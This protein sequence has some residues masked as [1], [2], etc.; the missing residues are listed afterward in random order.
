MPR[1][2]PLANGRMLVNF[3]AN[4][5]LR[6]IYWPHIG[7][8][9]HTL[10]HVNHSGVWVDG[11][12]SWF[13]SDGWQRDLRYE[14]DTLT[15]TVTLIHAGLQLRI[16]C[17]DAVDFYR[18]ILIRRMRVTNQAD[19]PREV[20]LFFHHDWHIWE[21]EGANTVYYRPD[22]QVIIAYKDTCYLL[23]DGVVGDDL[24]GAPQQQRQGD[25]GVHHWAT[26]QKEFEGKQ[27]TW[28][29]AEDGVLGGNP[30]AQGSVDSCVG[31]HLGELAPNQTRT[32]YHWLVAGETY[33]AVHAQ[34]TAVRARGPEAFIVR[35]HNYWHLWV[36]TKPLGACEL[37]DELVDLYKRSL[38]I[39]RSQTD[40]SGAIIAAT[41]ADVYTFSAD[42]YAYMWPRDGAL[43]SIA[44]SHA[45]YGDITE[46]FFRFCAKAITDDGYLLHK[47]TPAGALGSS[48]H[49]WMNDK[50]Q[51]VHPIQEDET[52]LVVY[53]LW[54]HYLLFREVEFIR[55]LYRH[56][57]KA[58]ADFMMSFR[59]PHTGLPAPSWDLWEERHGI[60]TFT[61]ASV[62]G[63][64][65]AAANFAGQFGE[66][67]H[68]ARYQQAA[69]EIKTAA[70][71]Y[72]WHD[73]EQRFLRMINVGDDGSITPDMTVDSSVA[74][75]F[76]IG[77]FE[78]QS[79]EMIATMRA[80]EQRLTVKTDVG[81]MARYENDYYQQV[82]QDTANVPGNPWFICACWLAEYK[83]ARA[84][85]LDE[86]REAIPWLQWVQSHALPSGVLAEQI[87]P[88]TGAP[89][90][91]SPL[92]WSHAQY[93]STV[94]WYAGKYAHLTQ[95]EAQI[96]G[97][98]PM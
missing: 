21:S 89:L 17:C 36:N 18:D 5:D 55:P 65:V 49:P 92:T 76:Q 62:Y 87:N 97:I 44:L 93:V 86:L 54:Q 26:G 23:V 43:V 32:C 91:V 56:L 51:L 74:G 47:Y 29:D 46:A 39:I 50:G 40:L 34:N 2:L 67:D 4:Y 68:Q 15:T 94:R 31:F 53:A 58:A 19:H 98:H 16:E 61:V 20:R 63:G 73:G 72:L 81:G 96:T 48:W 22:Q 33:Q 90:S 75:V 38:V 12:F 79:D 11:A 59:E 37:S 9:N 3:D 80:Y 35:T 66:M 28:R 71:K 14:E 82:S 24:A 57:I 1:N 27:G 6:D 77:M 78:A 52:A 25:L 84:Q 30:I 13:D 8:R 85:T 83:I 41:D 10:G 70:R 45:G 7:E 42:S 88:Y 64:L 95:H 69:D 60:H